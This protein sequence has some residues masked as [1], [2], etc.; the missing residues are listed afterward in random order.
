MF[1]WYEGCN[2]AWCAFTGGVVFSRTPS[3]PP[4]LYP[5]LEEAARKVGVKGGMEGMCK[6][7]NGQCNL[8]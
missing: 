5:S 6:V 1:V 8:K 2:K 3:L 7:D 4:S